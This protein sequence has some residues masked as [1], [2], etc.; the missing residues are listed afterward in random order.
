MTPAGRH[1]QLSPRS[2]VAHAPGWLPEPDQAL[3]HLLAELPWTQQVLHLYGR[4]VAQ[5]RLTAV[6]GRSMDPASRYRRPNPEAPWTPTAWAVREAVC[7]AVPS[8]EP[9]G[10]IANR[11]RDGADSISWHA[12]DEPALGPQP[13]V[14]SVSLGA[15]R[16]F[17]LRPRGGGPT[18]LVQLGHGDLLVMGGDTQREFLHAINKSG[19]TTGT[20]VSLT[21]RRYGDT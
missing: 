10:L 17:R 20:R 5:P 12:D 6:C 2:W 7:G 9:N 15:G 19:R 8:W 3:Q 11:Y 14:V 16:T 13:I 4:T 18:T 1:V 21:Y